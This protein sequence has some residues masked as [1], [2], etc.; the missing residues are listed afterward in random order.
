MIHREMMVLLSA[1]PGASSAGKTLGMRVVVAW[2]SR[3]W[4]AGGRSLYAM[5]VVCVACSLGHA[6]KA[7]SGRGRR[8][9]RDRSESEANIVEV[10][11]RAIGGVER[12][13]RKH[14]RGGVGTYRPDMFGMLAV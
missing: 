2:S 14:S 6:H 7:E 12:I 11:H 3:L 5:A 13:R 1:T 8:V 9:I 10:G 4:Q